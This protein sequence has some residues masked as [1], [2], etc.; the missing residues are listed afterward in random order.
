MLDEF[1][2]ND[3]HQKEESCAYCN[4]YISEG[5]N[6]GCELVKFIKELDIANQ[7]VKV[8]IDLCIELT[9]YSAS[10]E[11]IEEHLKDIK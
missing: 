10:K 11:E 5:H 9:G 8:L 1:T 7:K 4:G 2:K 6:E 3:R